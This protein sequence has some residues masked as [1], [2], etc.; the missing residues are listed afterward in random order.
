MKTF[1]FDD[2][3]INSD[4]EHIYKITDLILEKYPDSRIIY[5]VSL[6]TDSNVGQRVFDKIK[7]AHSDHSI[8][9]MANQIGF[10]KLNISNITIASHGLFHV[11]HR[12]ISFDAQEMSILGSCTLLGADTF[13]PPF[14]KWNSD[15]EKVCNKHNINLVKFEEGWKCMEYQNY[16]GY[17]HLWYL[18]AHEMTIKQVEEWLM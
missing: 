14:N 12:L 8:Y 18:H 7:N 6:I 17:S 1:R 9:Y 13:V 16:N 4:L 2:V 3:C 11:D 15:T 5:A 10:P